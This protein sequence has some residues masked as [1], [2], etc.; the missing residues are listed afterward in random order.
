MILL[1]IS[2]TSIVTFYYPIFLLILIFFISHLLLGANPL[3]IKLHII[4]ILSILIILYYLDINQSNYLISLLPPFCLDKIHYVHDFQIK[5]INFFEQKGSILYL[6]SLT[7]DLTIFL[8]N[9]SDN[10]NYWISLT[11]YPDISGYANEE[12]IKLVISDPIL[13]N[14]ESNS[15]L[16]TKFIMNRLN[17]MIDSYYLDDSIINNKN[18]VVIIKYTEIELK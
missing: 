4:R 9:L 3:S 8:D 12:G 15:L 1:I 6:N 16:L 7:R 18:S 5:S 17:L 11:F 2:V 13:I 14:K 10:D